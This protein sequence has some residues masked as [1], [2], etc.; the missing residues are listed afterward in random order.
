MF[1]RLGY[2]SASVDL[3]AAEAGVSKQTIY[4]HFHSKE[5]LFKEIV[6]D[7]TSALM[8][9]LEVPCAAEAPV[10][11]VLEALARDF[12]ILTLKPS[13]LAL[14]RLIVAEAERFP[15]L[16]RE[17]YAVGSGRVIRSLADYLARETKT[18]RLA[19]E[20]PERAAEQF[21]GMLG[22]R[23]QLRA[24]LGVS[25]RPGDTELEERA[26]QAVSGFLSLYAVAAPAG[27]V[28]G[29]DRRGPVR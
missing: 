1:L 7:I 23:I 26:K 19:I 13:T 5:E 25:D 8:A 27:A 3:I 12:L 10:A 4:N 14:Y 15:D 18:G 20:A 17:L 16:G 2:V 22:G 11:Q 6:T 9:P 29:G 24:L 28:S 21:I